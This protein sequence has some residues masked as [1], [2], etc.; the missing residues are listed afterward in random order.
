MQEDIVFPVRINRYLALKGF[1]TRR[2]AD[3]LIRGGKVRVNG[4]VAGL[5]DRVQAADKVEVSSDGRRPTKEF[6]YVAYYKPR[7]VVTHSPKKG[8][9]AIGDVSRFPGTFPVGRLDKASEGLMLLT[10]DGRV[11]ER[12]LHPRFGHEKE[13]VV[14]VRENVLPFVKETLEAGVKSNGERLTAKSVK[15]TGAHTL[16][17]VLTEGKKH[18]IR[19]MLDH[20]HLTVESL[21]RVRIMDLR[22]GALKSGQARPL[23]GRARQAFLES[24]GLK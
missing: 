20:V 15:I 19:R 11:T 4:K 12:M 1:A 6:V 21:K 18:Q 16:T 23:H 24:I 22:I 17:I 5:G 14:T 13:Y 7:G 3:D 9:K 2:G 8:E 10:N